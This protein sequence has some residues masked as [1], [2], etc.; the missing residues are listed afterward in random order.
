MFRKL[1]MALALALAITLQMPVAAQAAA[2]TC[3]VSITGTARIGQTLTASRSCTNTP[4][5]YTYQWSSSTGPSG[6]YSA[7]AGATAQTYVV[8]PSDLSLYIKVTVTGTNADGTSPAAVSGS[9]SGPQLFGADVFAGS[10]TAATVDGTGA[11]AS[12]TSIRGITSDASGNLYVCDLGGKVIRKITPAG[13]VT[14]IAGSGSASITDGVGTAASFKAPYSI[15]YSPNSNSLFIKDTSVVRELRLSDLQVT[16]LTHSETILTAARSGT[17]VTLTFANPHFFSSQNITVSGLG[18]PYDG[19][20]AVTY[21]A[22]TTITYAVGSSATVAAFSPTGATVSGTVGSTTATENNWWTVYESFKVGPDGNLY[23]IRSTAG[24]SNLGG[25]LIRFTRASGSSFQLQ[26]LYRWA[27]GSADFDFG[28]SVNTIHIDTG[29]NSSTYTTTDDW[30]TASATLLSSTHYNRGILFD[31]AGY[32]YH[33]TVRHN[34]NTGATETV[35]VSPGVSADMWELT[36]DHIYVAA[37]RGTKIMRYTNA[38]SGQNWITVVN[39]GVSPSSY[40]VT[41]DAN[42]GTG[43]MTP[44]VSI[45]ANNLTANAFTLSGSTFTGW[46]TAANGSGTPYADSANYSF[47]SSVTLFAQWSSGSAQSNQVIQTPATALSSISSWTNASCKTDELMTV[48]LEGE[49]LA[50]ASVTSANSYSRIVSASDTTLMLEISKIVNVVSWLRIVTSDAQITIQ[51]TFQCE[52]KPANLASNSL[53]V[54]FAPN[55]SVISTKESSRIKKLV[56]GM[57]TPVTLSIVGQT[58]ATVVSAGDSKLA[59]A[60]AKATAALMKSIFGSVTSK[61]TIAPAAGLGK[62]YRSAVITLVG[63]K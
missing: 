38:G 2:P 45:A 16:T 4:T 14:T 9:A 23:M 60:R 35:F 31:P 22:L 20:F 48:S 50:S 59:M 21:P 42:G 24:E 6:T 58:A 43:S 12:F 15:A 57:Q 41:F 52:P 25:Y 11:A 44:Q 29:T 61:I 33:N 13:V 18:A 47:T 56:A 19:T 7:I 39:G 49:G 28:V 8:Q 40:T 10:S 17:T 62:S 63:V 3:S 27:N 30:T 26:R 36:A 34:L 53:I 51:N 1:G 54:A 5:S 32:V 46:N 55:S 37:D